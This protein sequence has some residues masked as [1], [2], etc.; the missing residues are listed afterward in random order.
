MKAA[1]EEKEGLKLLWDDLKQ[2][3][4]KLCQTEQ[5]RRWR[6]RKEKERKNF[7]KDPFKYAHQLLE[8]K[9]SSK[10]AITK[11]DLE[12]YI[13]GLY[14]DAAKDTPLG[15]PVLKQHSARCCD[16][17]SILRVLCVP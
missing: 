1:P 17:V 10:L 16:F 11:A 3:L 5:I 2:R 15:S 8:E 12:H 13:K 7:F 9:Q 4:A 6:K 14:A